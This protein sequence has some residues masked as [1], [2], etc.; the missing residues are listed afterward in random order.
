MR[1]I[2]SMLM[3]MATVAF[4]APAFAVPV[5]FEAN[6]TGGAEIPPTTST[7]TGFTTVVL[8]TAA[9]TLHVDVT[10]SGLTSG[11][12]ASHI[13]CCV[14]SG[15]AGNFIVATTT[16]TF[17]GFPM[18]VTFG[19]YD[20]TLDLTLASSYNPVFVTDE[21]GVGAAELALEAAIE[22][23]TAYLNIHT[24]M[25]PGGEIRG[26]LEPAPEPASLILLGSALIGLV[27]CCG[28]ASRPTTFG[29]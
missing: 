21:G 23:G 9:H 20:H 24:M 19:N 8:D 12:T 28:I 3:L 11:T 18:G 6:L 1:Y 2:R 4:Q 29:K 14:A 25:F 16:P 13:H 26:I 5:T 7:A 27:C 15:A 17:P 10:F 22:A